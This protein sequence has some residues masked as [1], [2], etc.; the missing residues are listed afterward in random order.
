MSKKVATGIYYTPAEIVKA[1]LLGHTF[2]KDNIYNIISNPQRQEIIRFCAMKQRTITDI[3]KHIGLSY[4]PTWK[5]VNMLLEKGLVKGTPS[6]D[7]EKGSVVYIKTI[8]TK[9]VKMIK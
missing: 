2:D 3:Q 4:S 6:I 9:P 7:K 5:H 1:I 8:P